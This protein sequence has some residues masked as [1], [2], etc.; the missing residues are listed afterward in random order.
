MLGAEMAVARDCLA[1]IGDD[2]RHFEEED[3]KDQRAA[4]HFRIARVLGMAW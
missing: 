2:H 4:L 3:F 1:D